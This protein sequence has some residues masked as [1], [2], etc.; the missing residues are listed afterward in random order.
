MKPKIRQ[1]F[2]RRLKKTI[3]L[4]EIHVSLIDKIVKK[5]KIVTK[6]EES[7]SSKLTLEKWRT[8]SKW[9]FLKRKEKDNIS[10][11]LNYEQKNENK[12]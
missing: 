10:Q 2:N 5:N 7:L 6:R 4:R 12:N 9:Y 1:K 11:N 8:I 3:G